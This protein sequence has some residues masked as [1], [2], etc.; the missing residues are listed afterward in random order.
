MWF[1]LSFQPNIRSYAWVDPEGGYRG[2]RSG[3]QIGGA[4]YCGWPPSAGQRS[5]IPM[6][7]AG[8]PMLAR[9]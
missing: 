6:A 1:I 5:A 9:F 4:A 7:F 8:R 3:M 2:C